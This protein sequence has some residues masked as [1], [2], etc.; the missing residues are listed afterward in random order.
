ML[1]A[2]SF[3]CPDP[4]RAALRPAACAEG[5]GRRSSEQAT[6]AP[7]CKVQGV[8]KGSPLALGGGVGGMM[9]AGDSGRK[10]ILG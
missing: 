3:S 7:G 2:M 1:S 4:K 8:Q 5:P 9:E 6:Q 10:S